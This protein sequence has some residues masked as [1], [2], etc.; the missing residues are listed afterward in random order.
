MRDRRRT[1]EYK[2]SGMQKC[3]TK[4]V[5]ENMKIFKYY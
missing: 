3:A 4:A 2:G 5:M 1:R